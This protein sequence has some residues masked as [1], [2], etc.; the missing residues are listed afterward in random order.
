MARATAALDAC[1]HDAVVIGD[2]PYYGRFG[3]HAGLTEG[4]RLPG[5]FDPDRLLLRA[6]DPEAWRGPAWLAPAGSAR[7]AA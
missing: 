2:A 1:G 3:F 7:L 6:K 5:P 4:W